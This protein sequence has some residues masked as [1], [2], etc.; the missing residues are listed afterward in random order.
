[1]ARDYVHLAHQGE[2]IGWEIRSY[3]ASEST[4]EYKGREVLLVEVEAGGCSFCDGSYAH[5]LTGANVEGYVLRWQYRQNEEGM[6]VSE[7]E[8]V[9]DEA[10][11][12]EIAGV[13]KPRYSLSQIN[14]S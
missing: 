10:E 4:F 13:L 1:M 9:R 11:R 3:S 2:E 14:F 6:P 8:P 12:K 5:N 7:I